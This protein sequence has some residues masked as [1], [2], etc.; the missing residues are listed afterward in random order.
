M[1]TIINTSVPKSN[2]VSERNVQMRS[3]SLLIRAIRSPVRLP[4]KYSSERR[5]KW[6]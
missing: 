6:W 3:V 2:A 5:I 1:P 4:P